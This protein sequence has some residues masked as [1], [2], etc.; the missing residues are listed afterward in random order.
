MCVVKILDIAAS[1]TNELDYQT[2]WNIIYV[3]VPFCIGRCV[4]ECVLVFRFAPE[5][6]RKKVVVCLVRSYL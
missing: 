4:L 6:R 3:C 5:M 1:N 2:C